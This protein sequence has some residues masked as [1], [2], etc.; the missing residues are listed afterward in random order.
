MEK[1]VKTILENVR[2]KNDC[3]F[4]YIIQERMMRCLMIFLD[5]LIFHLK[6]NTLLLNYS[7]YLG[8]VNQCF[9]TTSK[10]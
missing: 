5:S 2:L 6:E 4:E 7:I 9:A 3:I 1:D 8:L 10:S